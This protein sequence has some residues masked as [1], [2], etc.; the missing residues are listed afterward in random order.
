MVVMPA[1]PNEMSRGFSS[2]RLGNGSHSPADAPILQLRNLTK[3]FGGLVAV[4][5]VS[6]EVPAGKVTALIGPNGAGKTSLFNMIAGII[7]PDEG[8]IVFD[9]QDITGW[10]PGRIVR[11]GLGRT[12]QNVNLFSNLT[13][14][15]NVMVA[16]YGRMQPPWFDPFI[17]RPGGTKHRKH[18]KESSLELLGFVGLQDQAAKTPEELSYGMQRRLEMA[19]ALATEPNLLIL[20]EPTAGV[21]RSALKGIVDLIARLVAGGL[22]VLLIEH[23][24]NVVM[25]LSNQ[26][27]V[28][29]FGAKIAE[30]PPEVVRTDERV[31]EAYLGVTH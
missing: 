26:V 15:E 17:W 30:G 19:R 12:F 9:G 29:N 22:T 27:V 7:E 25:A 4:S 18:V 28:M 31:V 11:A 20:D 23:N 16:R 10:T 21:D 8:S 5:G 3:R 1:A 14:L 2:D 13:A 24:M 6:F